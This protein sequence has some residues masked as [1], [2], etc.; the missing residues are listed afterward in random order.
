M[1]TY[2]MTIILILAMILA[3]PAWAESSKEE[4]D[5]AILDRVNEHY[6]ELTTYRAAYEQEA[7][8]PAMGGK[9]AI[10]FKDVSTGDLVFVKPDLIRLDQKDPRTEVLVS[11]GSVSWWYI[12]DEKK[13]YK[14]TA[15]TQSGALR[16]L[17]EVFS[18]K[19]KLSDSFTTVVLNSKGDSIKIRLKPKMG[20]SDFEYLDIDLDS[21]S[22]ELKGL[23]IS[24]L[25]GQSTKFTFFDIKEG[26][27]IP[28]DLFKFT[29][30]KGAEI[31]VNK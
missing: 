25:M 6:A 9:Q 8:S 31:I 2:K 26:A 5:K 16:A 14:Y 10:V 30:P 18:G 29:P 22:L 23:Y 11:D 12:P 15:Y 28:L 19:G 4:A 20:G 17:T 24:Y 1:R 3:S 21:K 27:D 13:A 7:E